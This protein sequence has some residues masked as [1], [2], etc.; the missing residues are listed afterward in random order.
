MTTTSNVLVND[1]FVT[2]TMTMVNDQEH[3]AADYMTVAYGL[4]NYASI[5]T[6]FFPEMKYDLQIYLEENASFEGVR[7]VSGINWDTRTIMLGRP[8]DYPLF[9][10]SNSAYNAAYSHILNLYYDSFLK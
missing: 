7:T 5:P 9:N 8:N 3:A 1:A 4:Q 6:I 10:S 2:D